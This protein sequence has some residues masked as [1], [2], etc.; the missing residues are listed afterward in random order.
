M[1]IFWVH[2][3]RFVLGQCTIYIYIY[4]SEISVLFWITNNPSAYVIQSSLLALA[5]H[6]SDPTEADRLRHLA[7]PAGKVVITFLWKLVLYLAYYLY[8]GITCAVNMCRMNIHNGWLLVREASLR[9]WLNFHQQSPHLVSSLQQLP[10]ACSL[11]SIQSH[12]PQGTYASRFSFLFPFSFVCKSESAFNHVIQ[13]RRFSDTCCAVGWGAI[14]AIW[15]G[16]NKLHPDNGC[17]D[18]YLDG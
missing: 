15:S 13:R 3:K 17:L 11:D 5:A 2:P 9:S 8:M 16:K 14:A 6:T 12:H 18:I 10:H 7:S 4:I 1:L